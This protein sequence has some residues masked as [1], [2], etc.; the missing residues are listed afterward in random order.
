MVNM[1]VQINLSHAKLMINRFEVNNK[2]WNF[3][4]DGF[5]FLLFWIFVF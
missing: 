4:C 2:L 3:R 5:T 1:K